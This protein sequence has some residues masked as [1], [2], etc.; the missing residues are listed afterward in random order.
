VGRGLT[1]LLPDVSVGD[2]I[3]P[4]EQYFE[5]Q[6]F[7]RFSL[8]TS[9]PIFEVDQLADFGDQ[10]EVFLR[11]D[12]FN[13][14]DEFRMLTF[15]IEVMPLSTPISLGVGCEFELFLPGNRGLPLRFLIEGGCWA[16]RRCWMVCCFC[17]PGVCVFAFSLVVL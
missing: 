13:I 7:G 3:K 15:E 4:V 10:F 6:E 5:D 8:G 12:G 16:V 1:L 14:T 9:L 2:V 17:C 11:T